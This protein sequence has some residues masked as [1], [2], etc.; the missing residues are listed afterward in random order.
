MGRRIIKQLK[1]KKT[2]EKRYLVHT[3][4]C[5]EKEE[6][7][8][9]KPNEEYCWKDNTKEEVGGKKAVEELTV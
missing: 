8:L 2:L 9:V 7:R 6:S 5:Y 4:I 1:K 3:F